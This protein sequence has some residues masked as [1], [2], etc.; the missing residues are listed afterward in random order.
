MS[1]V[2]YT[3]PNCSFCTK[4]KDLLKQ[5][6]YNEFEEVVVGVDVKSSAYKL[7]FPGHTTTPAII[8]NDKFI[9]GYTELRNYLI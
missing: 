2:I 1:I 5:V 8:I 4:A 3:K 7:M 6:G 9:G